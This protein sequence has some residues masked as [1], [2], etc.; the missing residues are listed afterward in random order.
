MPYNHTAVRDAQ[1]YC[2]L[3]LISHRHRKCLRIEKAH[4]AVEIRIYFLPHTTI[5]RNA[6]YQLNETPSNFQ[7]YIAQVQR[8]HRFS[9]IVNS[10]LTLH[11]VLKYFIRQAVRQKLSKK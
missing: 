9:T 5:F 11:A 3:N 2:I 4:L 6:T 7:A 10:H 1:W 8:K